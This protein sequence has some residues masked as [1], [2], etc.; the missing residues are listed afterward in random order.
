MNQLQ[1]KVVFDGNCGFCRKA[2]DW[3]ANKD[4]KNKLE[5]IERQSEQGECLLHGNQP[6]S[7]VLITESKTYY[8][9]DA[10]LQ[11]AKRLGFPYALLSLFLI[12]PRP[13]RDCAYKI[14]AQNRHRIGPKN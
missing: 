14:I 2:T 7:I 13:I 5:L 6:N 8:R 9:S 3:I 1:D 4:K 11:I 10:T 12:V